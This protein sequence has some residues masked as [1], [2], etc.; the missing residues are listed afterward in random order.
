[1]TTE[2]AQKIE[3]LAQTIVGAREW[4][5]RF[6][7]SLEK[8]PVDQDEIMLF[9][10]EFRA[11]GSRREGTEFSSELRMTRQMAIAMMKWLEAAAV[12]E[13]ESMG[14]FGLTRSQRS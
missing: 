3:L 9:G 4:L 5:R 11:T 1:M 6:E 14:G 12:A 8:N 13:L 2:E 10:G 7:N